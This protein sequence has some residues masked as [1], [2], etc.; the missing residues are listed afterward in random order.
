[1]RKQGVSVQVIADTLGVSRSTIY[2]E[3][4]KGAMIQKSKSGKYIYYKSVYDST[5]GQQV[6]TDNRKQCKRPL[7]L[8]GKYLFE[9]ERLLNQ[10]YSPEMAIKICKYPDYVTF[11]TV[12]NYIDKCYF[13][14]YRNIDLINGKRP[15]KKKRDKSY[16]QKHSKAN[17]IENRPD[18]SNRDVFGHWEMDT[19]VGKRSNDKCL[20]VISE[21]KTRQEIIFEMEDK[22][23]KSVVNRLRALQRYFGADYSKIFKS[24]TVDNGTEFSDIQGMK[25]FSSTNFYYCHPYSSWER[26]TNENRNKLIRRFIPKGKAIKNYSTDYIKS[27]E[28]FINNYPMRIHNYQKPIDLFNQELENLGISTKC[29]I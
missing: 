6:Y 21:R 7:K 4:R 27:V 12:Y 1:M 13:K 2:R 25:R 29:R 11:K 8:K 10:K 28:N 5:I 3:L 24:I 18:I 15:R 14:T 26:G 19:V 17:S 9:I 20:L 22:T 16:K 23:T